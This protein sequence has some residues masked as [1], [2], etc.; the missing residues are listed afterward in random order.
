MKIYELLKNNFSFNVPYRIG[1]YVPSADPTKEGEV[2]TVYNSV[3]DAEF[4]PKLY[5]KE[6]TAINFDYRF[7]I[8]DIEYCEP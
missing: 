3:L 2:I 6:I 7:G 4:N 5:D 8:V 1:R